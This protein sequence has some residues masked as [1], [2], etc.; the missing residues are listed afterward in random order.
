MD[1][2]RKPVLEKLSELLT[3]SW[4]DAKN[5]AQIAREIIPLNLEE[6]YFVQDRMHQLLDANISGWK[7]GA[8]SPK[9]REIDGHEDIIPGRIFCSRTYMGAYQSMDINLF[10]N[11]RAEAEFGFR[12]LEKPEVRRQP[13]TATEISSIM[14]LHPAVEIIGNRFRTEGLSKQETSLLTVADNGGGIGFVFGDL[15]AN[16]SDIN[17]K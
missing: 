2:A 10:P 12:L 14:V 3:S 15:I 9:M 4:S 11:A 13:W 7:V 5:P 1:E 17:F 16:W 6:A 8:T